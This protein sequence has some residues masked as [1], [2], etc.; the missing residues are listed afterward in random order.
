M[1]TFYGPLPL[2]FIT[3]L[4][5]KIQ[6]KIGNHLRNMSSFHISTF[7]NSTFLTFCGPISPHIF[8]SYFRDSPICFF[9]FL[10]FLEEFFMEQLLT[11]HYFDKVENHRKISMKPE[12]S[13]SHLSFVYEPG[14]WWNVV[15]Y[16]YLWKTHF[17]NFRDFRESPNPLKIPIP[18]PASNFYTRCVISIINGIFF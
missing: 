12:K 13:K 9:Q 4:L 6:D 1:F 8:V 11:T 2:L 3:I 14:M 5:Q 10:S 15:D 16:W 18:T 7:W 17:L